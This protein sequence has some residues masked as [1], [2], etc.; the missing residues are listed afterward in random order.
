M[1]NIR[2]EIWV[3]AMAGLYRQ[4]HKQM[5]FIAWGRAQVLHDLLMERSIDIEGGGL[6]ILEA[7][8]ELE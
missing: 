3:Q 8:K 7:L 4:A 5:P 2:Q 1:R 6:P